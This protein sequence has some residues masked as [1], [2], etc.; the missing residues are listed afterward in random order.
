M[1]T[2]PLALALGA[3]AVGPDY[4]V[5]SLTLPKAYS[6]ADSTQ[7]AAKPLLSH[8]WARLDDPTLNAL[9]SEAV[10]GNLDVATAKARV[11][12]ARATYRQSEG[13]LLPSLG[14]TSSATRRRT[15]AVTAGG[16]NTPA[17]TSTQYQAGFDASWEI[18]LFGKNQRGAEAAFYGIEAAD[19]QLRLALL[20]LVG[21]IATNYVSARGFQ[22]RV[23]LAQDTAKA[24]R[25]TAELT[26]TRFEA[27][28]ASAVDL[29]NAT[30]QAR[31]T[32]AA[33]P[34]LTVS[35]AE[36]VHR[37]SVLTGRAPGDLTDRMK[38]R[39]PIPL[40][41]LPMP[42]GIPADILLSRPDVRSAERQ[43]AQATAR[44][45]QAEAAKYPTISLTGNVATSGLNVGDLA[46]SSSIGWSFGPSLTVPLFRGGQLQAAVEVAQAQRDQNFM[47]YRAAVL[48]S[49][50]EVENAL[51]ALAQ[52]RLRYGK[53]VASAEAYRQAAT[54]SRKLYESGSVDFL[55]VL[56]AERSLYSA[57]DS[58]VQSRITLANSYV[59]LNKALGGG[60]DG[61]VD[62]STPEIVD[63]D[64]P[65]RLAVK[66]RG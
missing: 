28:A 38:R 48:R 63:Q 53:L 50:E 33:I 9:I 52:E 58:L 4:M 23:A 12:E 13:S 2:F 25:D 14:G 8:W 31:T 32:E 49:L 54:L 61:G 44:I 57:E 55:T 5:P 47:A 20:T 43:L 21:D 65:P 10:Q 36:A 56:D 46:K 18:D 22:A 16:S 51:V 39:R 60:W 41:K 35:Y 37:L 11:R 19:E 27:G 29:A 59:A 66:S 6:E 45:G 40:P 15:A 30:G 62:A 24:Q 26:R 3:C 1:C 42:V 17:Q 64:M 7:A 34:S